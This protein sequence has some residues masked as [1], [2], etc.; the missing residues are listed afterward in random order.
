MFIDIRL[1]WKVEQLLLKHAQNDVFF[2]LLCKI[3]WLY[4]RKFVK[5]LGLFL[6]R[7]V[8]TKKNLGGQKFVKTRTGKNRGFPEHCALF[9][10]RIDFKDKERLH[11]TIFNLFLFCF[12]QSELEPEYFFPNSTIKNPQYFFPLPTQTKKEKKKSCHVFARV[13]ILS[14]VQ[15]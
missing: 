2:S 1:T 7:C 10:K 12:S 6:I 11:I 15:F 5:L 3:I 8:F 14:C 9:T 13:A 4:N